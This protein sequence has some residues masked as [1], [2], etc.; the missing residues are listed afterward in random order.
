MPYYAHLFFEPDPALASAL[1]A[2]LER[3]QLYRLSGDLLGFHIP[4]PGVGFIPDVTR[5]HLPGLRR[6]GDGSGEPLSEA[7]TQAWSKTPHSASM[8]P[9]PKR[10]EQLRDLSGQHQRAIALYFNHERGDN[11]YDQ[12]VWLVE[13]AQAPNARG[14]LVQ[15]RLCCMDDRYRLSEFVGSE[16][17]PIETSHGHDAPITLM[18]ARFGVEGWTGYYPPDDHSSFDHSPYLWS[19]D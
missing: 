18:M 8:W 6:D 1:K 9:D 2:Q 11:L 13:P 7:Y 19:L 14:H 15:E 16:H 10:L 5:S 3:E 12:F 4:S 17:A